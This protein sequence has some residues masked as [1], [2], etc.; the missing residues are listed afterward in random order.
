MRL[1]PDLEVAVP[2]V[3]AV[4]RYRDETRPVPADGRDP[5]GL[6][7]DVPL[8][9]GPHHVLA[10]DV[11]VVAG[12][13]EL[14]P[15][16]RLVHAQAREVRRAADLHPPRAHRVGQI[17][18]PILVY[19][20]SVPRV[21][22]PDPLGRAPF[23]RD[24][25]V[26]DP[27]LLPVAAVPVAVRVVGVRAVDVEILGVRLEDGESPR[28]VPVVPDRDAGEDRLAP[29]DH[30]PAR[31]DEVDEIAQRR[32]RLHPVRIVRHQRV[33]AQRAAP[34]HD[35]VVA[36][37]P[38]P[39]RL[40]ASRLVGCRLP[41]FLFE[42]PQREGLP[43]GG[44]GAEAGLDVLGLEPDGPA[45]GAVHVEDLAPEERA[46]DRGIEID[47]RLSRMEV[48]DLLHLLRPHLRDGDPQI[49]LLPDVHEQALVAGD[50]DVRGPRLRTD[51]E[52]L[53]LD[54]KE[55]RIAF[56]LGDVRVDPVREGPDDLRAARVIVIQFRFQI[57]AEPEQPR[58]AVALQFTG[59]EDFGNRARGLAAPEF[60][61]EEAVARGAVPLRE[62]E[63]VLRLR[64]DVAD[65]PQVLEDLDPGLEP[66]D[67]QGLRVHRIEGGDPIRE[68]ASKVV[69]GRRAGQVSTGA[70]Q[71]RQEEDEREQRDGSNPHRILLGWSSLVSPATTPWPCSSPARSRPRRRSR[72]PS[73]RTP[74]RSP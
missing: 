36:P 42:R 7:A 50:D 45:E 12:V 62:E 15:R 32:C 43:V 8:D 52:H 27:H 71:D 18:V 61:L 68:A 66:R 48:G 60:E 69:D 35:P 13:P 22:V 57:A 5:N 70:P 34:R 10:G 17:V 63:I 25:I 41:G 74:R 26:D 29:A 24:L 6:P 67:P 73:R 64:V 3:A 58:T 33:A 59:T 31:S 9:V 55:A 54:R 20:G 53:E 19:D 11:R 51:P 49:Q 40:E 37:R 39:L 65:A 46:V 14:L 47:V 4:P 1:V 44:G 23:D 56:R 30:I 16:L 21:P 72:S 2:L 38:H 28:T